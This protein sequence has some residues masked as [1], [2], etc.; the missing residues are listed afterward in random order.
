MRV[1]LLTLALLLP[2]HALA[3]DLDPA[4]A[5]DPVAVKQ[6]QSDLIALGL[7]KGSADG[8]FGKGSKRALSEWFDRWDPGQTVLD[9]TGAA[10]LTATAANAATSPWDDP[11]T[12]FPFDTAIVETNIDI[13][14]E[15]PL[16]AELDC[17]AYTVILGTG[18]MSGDG[19]PEVV[20]QMF[21]QTR[22][23][24]DVKSP[25]PIVILSP[26]Q[27][28]K[29]VR[30][31][32]KSDRPEGIARIHARDAVIRD[33]NGD[34]RG[35]LF[36]AAHGWDYQPFPGEQN[37]LVL[38]GPDG[39]TDASFTN[40]PVQDDFAHGT[41]AADLDKD[42]DQD[43]IVMTHGR[44]GP[45]PYVLWND[46]TGAFTA[47]ALDTVLTG[48]LG[49]RHGPGEDVSIFSDLDIADLDGDGNLD[50]L[51]RPAGFNQD[52][53]DSKPGMKRTR[54]LWGD[55]SGLWQRE[56]AQEL[57]VARFGDVTY[58]SAGQVTDID[59]DG[60]TDIV[61]GSNGTDP[62]LKNADNWKGQYLQ[63]FRND[64][65]RRF[66]DITPD[67]IYGQSYPKGAVDFPWGVT[68]ADLNGDGFADLVVS[69]IADWTPCG[70][71]RHNPAKL[72]LVGLSEGSPKLRAVD[73]VGKVP[74]GCNNMA[75]LHVGDLD[76]DGDLDLY[77]TRR[78]NTQRDDGN[79]V[80]VGVGLQVML[81][82]T[83]P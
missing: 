8:Q 26:T 20:V 61:L 66:T 73:A 28:G 70:F 45:E 42:G 35:D 13:R 3:Q 18:D 31:L 30:L 22:D 78:E 63:V 17:F 82:R 43:L 57:P 44:S 77:G 12:A 10:R 6:A 75:N 40:L 23:G 15:H 81:N 54:I 76:G 51:L 21:V 36:I 48:G 34:G 52:Y 55:G 16:C 11:A 24:E 80:S 53:A 4:L 69:T 50:L 5:A 38:T 65:A 14:R 79:I 2:G 64:G 56:A 67:V 68:M 71:E 41:D 25:N 39:L 33:M 60:D 62:G 74:E 46:G 19:K 7:L 37:V 47:A 27:G 72:G 32:V 29:F 49:L 1:L 58:A 83:V 59:G 9:A